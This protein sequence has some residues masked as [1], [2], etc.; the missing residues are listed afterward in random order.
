M[1]VQKKAGNLLKA[2]RIY[3]YIYIYI[4]TPSLSDLAWSETQSRTEFW[5][6]VADF[7]SY[8]AIYYP[9]RVYVCTRS[10]NAR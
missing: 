6:Q 3:I 4:F 5:T 2:P 9:K 10:N 7:I 1:L 8:V